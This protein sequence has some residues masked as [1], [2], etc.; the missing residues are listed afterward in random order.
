MRY[1]DQNPWEHLINVED[2][3]SAAEMVNVLI[4]H[5]LKVFNLVQE[6]AEMG[7]ARTFL[8]WIK[9]ERLEMFTARDCSRRFRAIKKDPRN[10]GLKVLEEHEII[11]GDRPLM[12]KGRPSEVYF[13]NPKLFE[14]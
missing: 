11:K 5:A 4:K 2:M 8:R 6:P 13:V 9:S 10:D 3:K 12:E 14:K 1:A 7:T